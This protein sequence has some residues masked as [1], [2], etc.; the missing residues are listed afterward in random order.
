MRNHVI[1]APKLRPPRPHSSRWAR[2]SGRRQ[3]A[4]TNPMPLTARNSTVKTTISVTCPDI[5]AS[6]P[7][8]RHLVHERRRRHAQ[9]DEH[10]LQPVEPWEAEHSRIVGVEERNQQRHDDGY[11][12]QP[13]PG[14]A[15]TFPP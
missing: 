8:L 7:P 11:E 14:T 5:A 9:Q 6:P 13:V 15:V 10:E 12:Q 3:R 4:A 1:H 2:V